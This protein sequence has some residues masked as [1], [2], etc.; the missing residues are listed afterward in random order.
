LWECCVMGFL[1]FLLW[2]ALAVYSLTGLIFLI[3]CGVRWVFK[4]LPD[5]PD[6]VARRERMR[7]DAEA[8]RV[9]KV[10]GVRR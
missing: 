7:H 3:A 8:V 10:P 1:L 9:G 6:V 2:F 4:L 5:N